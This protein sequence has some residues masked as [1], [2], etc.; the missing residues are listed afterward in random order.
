VLRVEDGY[1]FVEGL[2]SHHAVLAPG[3]L[4]RRIEVMAGVLGLTV[5]RL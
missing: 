3:A 5:E 2:P 1:R 4:S